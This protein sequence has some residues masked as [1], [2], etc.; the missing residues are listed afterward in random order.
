MNNK[1]NDTM[2]NWW[3]WCKKCTGNCRSQG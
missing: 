1:R 2:K 3:W